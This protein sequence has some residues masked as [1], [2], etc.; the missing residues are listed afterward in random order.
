MIRWLAAVLLVLIESP[1][2][3]LE[4]PESLDAKK[5]VAWCIVPFDA[6]KRGP[7]ERA[8]MLADLGIRRCAYDW[9]GEHVKEFEDEILQ[10][11]KH[12][13][14]Y[15]A[16]WGGHE[17]AFKLFEK[18]DL[19][20][21]IW[22]TLGSPKEGNQ[23]EKVEAAAK[24]ME[25]LA[26]RAA[27]LG[28]KL[29]LYNH[30]GWGGEPKNLVAVCKRLHANGH[31]HVGI[32]YNW[33]HGHGH[34][35]DW[36]DSLKLM[37]PYLLCLNLNGMNP[38]AKPKIL[39][40]AQGKHDLAML[41]AVVDSGYD[42]PIGILD[43]Q[44][45]LDAKEALQDNRDG[46]E[47]LKKELQKPGSG[48]AK[49]VPKATKTPPP[50]QKPKSVPSVNADFG[51]ALAGA[52][53][54]LNGRAEWREPPITVECRAKLRDANGYNILVA[55]DMKK[56]KAHWEI[57]SM[58]G[59][60]TLTVYLPGAKPDHVRSTKVITDNAWHA[61]AMQY[62]PDRVR[63]WVD[64]ATVADQRIKL[65]AK[66]R[67]VPGGFGI[68]RL[69]EG[70]LGMRGA[71]DEVR[72]RSGIHEEVATVAAR[73]FTAGTNNEIA[74]WDSE[75]LSALLPR[76]G[77]FPRK[78]L[79]VRSN[80]YWQEHINRDRVY[81]FYAKQALHY[82]TMDPATLPK[83]L[84]PYPG[85][86]GGHYGH[87]GNQNDQETWKDGRVRDMDH[88]SMVSGVFRGAG[89]T[90]PCAVTVSIEVGVKVVFDQDTLRFGP[91]WKG[92]SVKWSDVR[93]GL[94][95]GI[96]MG[97]T[98]RVKI[99]E[100][101]SV[102]GGSR[103]E[104]IQRAG[105][106]VVFVCEHNGERKGL[107]A[108]IRNGELIVVG[109]PVPGPGP[110]QW[111]ERIT[112]RGELGEGQPYVIDTLT[113]PYVNPWRSLFFVAGVDFLS[114]DRIAI[115]NMHGDVW[116]CDVLKEDLSELRWKRFAAGLHQPLGLKVVDGI[117]HVM[118]RD[119]IVALH[120]Q[121]GDDEADFYGCVSNVHFT[122]SGGHD[123]IAD[124]QRDSEGRWY[125]GSGNQGV[126]RVSADGKKL[127]VLGTGLRNPNGV[128]ISPDGS[129]V[130]S[131]AQEG[132]WTPA[133]SVC[134]LSW[135]GHFGFGG[136]KE[137]ERGYVPPM[138]YLPRGADNSTGGQTFIDSDRWGP[139]KGNWVHFSSGYATH[140]LL[141]REVVGK[142]S[143]AAAVPLRGAFV[144]GGH[145]GRFSPY[146]GQ[147]YVGSAQGWGNYGIK[148]G[149][150]QRVR[151]T[152]GTFG[153]P[154]GFETRENG[155]ILTF[156]ESQN[157]KIENPEHW[158]A[159][160]WNYVY[161]PA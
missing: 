127:E 73:P 153:Y 71:I 65:L 43:H 93:H 8:K 158:F 128:G 111:P 72:I 126:C 95:H 24:M 10:Y 136:P 25:S 124:L 156:A 62:A 152:G 49:P 78:P 130:L 36:A 1:T 64:G 106:D 148:D 81:D 47:W 33:H 12:G 56:S 159:Q 60:G 102:P 41:K 140:F 57:F 7:A 15:F 101:A 118:C 4:I 31:K 108:E 139:V 119:Q 39:T 137:G 135:G 67:V 131:N 46:L 9:R 82:G 149:G 38:G 70:Q 88:G 75:D 14:E 3:A 18:H 132:T 104:G 114:K 29:G 45:D 109:V 96:P 120:D 112:T 142:Q 17:E 2:R 80:P 27:E 98:R 161:G 19:H 52:G 91:A 6:K 79:D 138:L 63:L 76:T 105:D 150:L 146:D 54:L 55:S 147:L 51:K 160:H 84:P 42:G 44:N 32:V 110:A 13:I 154:I 53:V 30:G 20:P 74:Y 34:I 107:R 69:V 85:L 97:G 144:S 11:K 86:D 26:K 94:M 37:K 66:R 5:L 122:S 117:I 35:D 151:Y 157:A 145:R 92:A 21:Q 103:F 28:C 40:L 59:D 50:A 48:G 129:V 100:R 22:R 116:I 125:F 90:I 23:E 115:C 89:K 16:F 113:L 143:Q 133:S 134:D 68:G 99:A 123:F 121:N 77:Q 61:I 83:V 155:L 141:L 58:D 87:W